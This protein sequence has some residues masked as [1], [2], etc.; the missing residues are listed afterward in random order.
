MNNKFV[1]IEGLDGAG[2]TTA[3]FRIIKY[4]NNR[5]IMKILT[6]HEPGGTPIANALRVLIKYGLKNEPI[7]DISE[8]LMIYA[9]RFQLSER[10]IKPALLQGYWV[11]GDRYDLSSQAYQGSRRGMNNAL[12]R[13]LSDLA[14]NSLY[15]DLTLYLDIVPEISLSRIKNRKNL[16]RIERESLSFFYRVYSR[17]RELVNSKKNVIVIDA[18][19]PLEDMMGSIYIHLDRWMSDFNK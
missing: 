12:L 2:K 11:I 6:T 3:I 14:T 9:A 17:Y 4:L 5:G 15:P 19:Q 8:L 16:D 1:T 13:T 18:N 10:V 7:H